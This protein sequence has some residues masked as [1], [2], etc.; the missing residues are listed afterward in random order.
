MTQ[1]TLDFGSPKERALEAFEREEG[2]WLERIRAAARELYA[3]LGRP[4]SAD[5]LRALMASEP[6]LH[7]PA[8]RS[9]NIMGSVF[10]RGWRKAGRVI[11]KRDNAHENEIRTWE[12]V[13]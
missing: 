11:S 1:V 5:D 3:A 6:R 10:R 4:I 8:D 9:M 7:P 2:P 12:P 13:R